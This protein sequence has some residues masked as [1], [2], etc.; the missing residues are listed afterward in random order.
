MRCIRLSV[1][2]L[3]FFQRLILNLYHLVLIQTPSC[4][5]WLLFQSCLRF[6]PS[7]PPCT[8]SP[9][10]WDRQQLMCP[11]EIWPPQ[12]K[13]NT[14]RCCDHV[15]T[16]A[17]AGAHAFPFILPHNDGHNL[18]WS[19]WEVVKMKD[20]SKVRGVNKSKLV[21]WRMKAL[22]LGDITDHVGTCPLHSAHPSTTVSACSNL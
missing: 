22:V 10:L 13:I 19:E 5:S 12:H 8:L 11:P 3:A 6:G 18:P 21:K 15:P 4:V 14:A 9:H 16:L 1:H 20:F 17:G 7:L 2:I